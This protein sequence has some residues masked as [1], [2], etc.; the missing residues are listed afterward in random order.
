[1]SLSSVKAQNVASWLSHYYLTRTVVRDVAEGLTCLPNDTFLLEENQDDIGRLFGRLIAN[2]EAGN[3]LTTLLKEHIRL[4]IAVVNAT[5]SSGN[6]DALLVDV[7]SNA[8]QV[9]DHY[10]LHIQPMSCD[11]MREMMLKH[12]ELVVEEAGV[13]LKHDYTQSMLE[14]VVG[15]R[16]LEMMAEYINSFFDHKCACCKKCKCIV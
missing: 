12:I 3:Q 11:K 10:C 6:V 16:H 9:A 1:M 5:V 14:G 7:K 4:L 15:I 2:E 8:I 13:I